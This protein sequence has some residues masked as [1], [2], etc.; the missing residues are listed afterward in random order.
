M[1]PEWLRSRLAHLGI[2]GRAGRLS[3]LRPLAQQLPPQVLSDLL[4][5]SIRTAVGLAETY[6]V[7]D[8][9]YLAARQRT[10]TKRPYH[11]SH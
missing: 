2:T 11:H 3:G 10:S 4:G 6:R 8:S 1:H 9:E 7:A 5:Y